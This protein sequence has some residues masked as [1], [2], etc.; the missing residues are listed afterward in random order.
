ML[1]VQQDG[2]VQQ[3]NTECVTISMRRKSVLSSTV[4]YTEENTALGAFF[5]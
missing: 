3:Q 5:D 1:Q 2:R 4:D